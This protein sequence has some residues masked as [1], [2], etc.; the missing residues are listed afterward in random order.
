MQNPKVEDDDQDRG[1]GRK[2]IATPYPGSPT[3]SDS[4]TQTDPY[5]TSVED[6]GVQC[7][8]D[9]EQEE[10]LLNT[11]RF[12]PN[13]EMQSV[14][15]KASV[16]FP[17]SKYEDSDVNLKEIAGMPVDA[18]RARSIDSALGSAIDD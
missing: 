6:K 7:A 14:T 12:E 17:Q 1:R 2:V 8:Y 5:A 15:P 9:G 3:Y 18:T 16:R 11:T 10:G 13:V 4:S